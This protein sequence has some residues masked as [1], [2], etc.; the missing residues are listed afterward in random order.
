[1]LRQLKKTDL[2]RVNEIEQTVHVIPWTDDTFHL[3]FNVGYLSWV[4]EV[5]QKI[6]GFVIVSLTADE[7]HVLNLGVAREH[8]HQGYGTILMNHVIHEAKQVG[9]GIIYLEVRKSNTRAI[10]LY[11]KLDFHLIGE[12]K[13]YYPTVAGHEDAL[14]F[15]KNLLTEA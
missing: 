15:A 2:T 4:C 7:C 14:I 3:C 11:R 1:M 6:V 12:R 10:S 5:D 8:Q 13:D 9:A